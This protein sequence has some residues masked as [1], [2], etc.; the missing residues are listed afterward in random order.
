MAHAP[1]A[2]SQHFSHTIASGDQTVL[3]KAE[4]VEG[5]VS[6]E[7]SSVEPQALPGNLPWERDLE[8]VSNFLDRKVKVIFLISHPDQSCDYLVY[9]C[10]YI[11]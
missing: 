1:N 10:S 5:G 8:M 7:S 9:T 6:G 11:A 3:P 4:D 2:L